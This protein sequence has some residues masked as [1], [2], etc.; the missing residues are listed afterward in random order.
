MNNYAITVIN[1]LVCVSVVYSNVN[2]PKLSGYSNKNWNNQRVSHNHA[3]AHPNANNQDKYNVNNY[4]DNGNKDVDSAGLMDEIFARGFKKSPS[5]LVDLGLVTSKKIEDLEKKLGTTQRTFV[6]WIQNIV[7]TTTTVASI[8]KE[9][10]KCSC[11]TSSTPNKIVGGHDAGMD[12][13]PWMAYLTYGGKFY[14]AACIIN[15]KFLLTAAH[16]VD[17]FDTFKIMVHVGA[18]ERGNKTS[19]STAY[20]VESV[21]KHSGYSLLNYNND[22]ALI[23][24]L[25]RMKFDG[26]LKPV[27]LPERG[28]TFAGRNASVTGWGAVEESGTLATKLQEVVVPI[29]SNN[30][31]RGT[32]YPPKKITDNMLC[33]GFLDGGKDS[34]Q[35]DSGGPLHILEDNT[36]HVVGIVSWGEGC[37][38]EGYPGVYSRVNRYIT[39]IERNTRGSCFC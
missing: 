37:A 24:I 34:C 12:Q 32:K 10:P 26:P 18:F 4:N 27:C 5:D 22:I 33:A 15:D 7:G 25:G 19:K 20:R 13:F 14:C 23:K 29:L 21:I 30:E 36:Y 39:W 16:C 8:P 3:N 2:Y 11:G 1:L 38:L 28:S 17:R 35:G 9:C 31:C 6:E